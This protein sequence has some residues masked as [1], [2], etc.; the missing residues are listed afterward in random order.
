MTTEMIRLAP[1]IGSITLPAGCFEEEIDPV[2]CREAS[3][4]LQGYACLLF[5]TMLLGIITNAPNTDTLW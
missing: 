1:Q 4:S 2:P 3:G 5:Q